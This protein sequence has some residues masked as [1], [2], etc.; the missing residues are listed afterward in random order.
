M[1]LIH[2]IYTSAPTKR[3]FSRAELDA[4]LVVARRNNAAAKISGL[5]LY[6]N[7][8]FFQILEG[9]RDSVEALFRKISGDKRHNRITKIVVEAIDKR[10]FGEW[11]MG[12]P[13]VKPLE[14]A[15]IPGL[16]DFFTKATSFHELGEGRAKMLLSA[17]REGRWRKSIT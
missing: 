14:L 13:D 10:N 12:F 2:L 9:E 5:L 3:E 11:K 8:S 4:L 16:N 7:G 6:Q 17:F 15:T 1:G